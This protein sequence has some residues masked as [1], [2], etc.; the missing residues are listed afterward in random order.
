MGF[1]IDMYFSSIAGECGTHT[2]RWGE[3]AQWLEREF[4]DR[5]VLGSNPTSASRLPLSM[6]RQP[7]SIPTLTF[8]S[9]GMAARHQKDVTAERRHDGLRHIVRQ[10][11][12]AWAEIRPNLTHNHGFFGFVSTVFNFLALRLERE[13]TD[14]KVRGSNPTSAFRL[15]CLGLGN[16]AIFPPACFLLVAP[17][18]FSY[19]ANPLYIRCSGNLFTMPPKRNV[20]NKIDDEDESEVRNEKLKKGGEDLQPTS[21]RS[22]KKHSK[23]PGTAA[24]QNDL[25][26]EQTAPETSKKKGKNKKRDESP[27]EPVQ[28]LTGV[29]DNADHGGPE[30][31][32]KTGPQSVQLQPKEVNSDDDVNVQPDEIDDDFYTKKR[33]AGRGKQKAV[34]ESETGA[35]NQQAGKKKKKGGGKKASVDNFDSDKEDTTKGL[36]TALE[37]LA[38]T[39]EFGSDDDEPYQSSRFAKFSGLTLNGEAEEAPDVTEPDA[40]QDV[41]RDAASIPFE[42]DEEQKEP[43][44]V[45]GEPEEAA[46]AFANKIA[47]T[48]TAPPDLSVRNATPPESDV[49]TEKESSHLVLSTEEAPVTQVKISKKDLKKLKKREEFDKLVEAA[50]EKIV[51]NSGTLDNFALS[52][53][54]CTD[55]SAAGVA[56]TDRLISPLFVRGDNILEVLTTSGRAIGNR[57]SADAG[58]WMGASWPN[59]LE[60]E[61]TDRKVR[62]SNPTSASRLPLSRL[63]QPGSIPALVQHSGDMA[64]RH[65][66][67]ATA[68]CFCLD[69]GWLLGPHVRPIRARL[70][71]GSVIGPIFWIIA[72]ELRLLAVATPN[73]EHDDYSIPTF[74]V[75]FQAPISTKVKAAQDKQ[76]DIKVENFSI[77]AKGKDLFVNAS[78]QIT[79]GRRYGLVGPNGLFGMSVSQLSG[80]AANLLTGRS[81]LACGSRLLLSRP[82][83]PFSRRASFRWHGS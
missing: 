57:H 1:S 70:D 10:G 63:G 48:V 46:P 76:L 44:A 52:Q 8:P 21:K 17:K 11:T 58:S 45:P 55:R 32:K 77:A 4:T 62:G 50:K 37:T 72:C 74:A 15:L 81:N 56:S 28:P 3:V 20:R 68:E 78:L 34:A 24:A 49:I 61:F 42:E 5:R 69:H 79:H 22:Q 39:N 67:G 75:L 31:G 18:F 27:A 13:F 12:Y 40:V 83:K 6:L 80:Q 59:W 2:S 51:S 19:R 33:R 82:W 43:L 41:P 35:T 65:R 64:V 36:S 53:A 29:G 71:T 25:A 73:C 14:L 26:N 16:L 30:R 60:R 38:I 54:S 47:D 23:Q 9:D 7:G 66:K